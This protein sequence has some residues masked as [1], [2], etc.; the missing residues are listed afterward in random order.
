MKIKNNTIDLFDSKWCILDQLCILISIYFGAKP[1]TP[2]IV[3]IYSAA[4]NNG[5]HY[6]KDLT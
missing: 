4:Y 2:K 6:A 3:L 5:T 1:K